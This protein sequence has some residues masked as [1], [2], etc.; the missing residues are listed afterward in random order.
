M[1]PLPAFLAK[2]LCHWELVWEA[3]YKTINRSADTPA[4]KLVFGRKK[5]GKTPVPEFQ[6]EHV[7]MT[8]PCFAIFSTVIS[9][10]VMKEL[11]RCGGVSVDSIHKLFVVGA[12]LRVS[13]AIYE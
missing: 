5:R 2:A 9:I 1:W 13:S 3:I 8:R 12:A 7:T 10:L 11:M 6:Q 4:S